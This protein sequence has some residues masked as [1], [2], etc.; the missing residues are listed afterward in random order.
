MDNI[1]AGAIFFAGL[2]ALFL[3]TSF[4]IKNSDK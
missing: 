2:S 1:C 3:L 4:I